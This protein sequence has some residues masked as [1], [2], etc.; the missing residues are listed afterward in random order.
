MKI[1]RVVKMAWILSG[2]RGSVENAAQ[3]IISAHGDLSNEE[4]QELRTYLSTGTMS[5][6]LPFHGDEGGNHE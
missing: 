2:Y 6:M 1:W 5:A 4:K 3:F